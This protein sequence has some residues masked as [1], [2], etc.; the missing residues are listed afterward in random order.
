[1]MGILYQ[2]KLLIDYLRKFLGSL[3]LVLMIKWDLKIF[4]GIYYQRKIKQLVPVLSI[5]LKFLILI[6]MGL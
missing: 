5:G 3:N 2:E 1:M 6:I 4:Y